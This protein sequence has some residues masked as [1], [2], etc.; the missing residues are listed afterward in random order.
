MF[1]WTK[2]KEQAAQVKFISRVKYSPLTQGYWRHDQIWNYRD[3]HEQVFMEINQYSLL[4]NM[5][6]LNNGC[7]KAYNLFV[8]SCSPEGIN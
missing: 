7:T 3:T 1:W 5:N 4:V 8:S 2:H 6:L